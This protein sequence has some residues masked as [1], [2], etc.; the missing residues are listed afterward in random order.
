MNQIRD[1]AIAQREQDIIKTEKLI[2][3]INKQLKYC[4]DKDSKDLLSL[5]SKLESKLI[6]DR[7]EKNDLENNF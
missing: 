3:D 4:S 5:K 7:I 1:L 2:S 6:R